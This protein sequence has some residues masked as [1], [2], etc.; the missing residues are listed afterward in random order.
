LSE[1]ARI[2]G[3]L[4]DVFHGELLDHQPGEAWHGPSTLGLVQDLS[5]ADAARK[6]VPGAH[7]IWE[8]AV[9]IGNWNEIIVRRLAGEKMEGLINTEADWPKHAEGDERAWRE[10]VD[11]LKRSYEHLHAAIYGASDEKLVQSAVGRKH[12]N[13]VMLHGIIDHNVYHSGQIALLRKALSQAA[14]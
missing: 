14:S 5:A 4:H 8:L 2:A 6:P 10:T 13:Y 1:S 11:R 7:S 12:S 9:H 3:L